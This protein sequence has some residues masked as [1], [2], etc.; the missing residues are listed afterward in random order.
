MVDNSFAAWQVELE[1]Y[2]V[3]IDAAVLQ[4]YLLTHLED[5]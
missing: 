3:K 4:L 1:T 5:V 2:L